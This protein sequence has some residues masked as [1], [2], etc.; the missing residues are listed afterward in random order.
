M[1]INISSLK[2]DILDI[3]LTINIF[4][5]CIFANGRACTLAVALTV[6]Y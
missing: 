3:L 1:Q 6:T 5:V 2:D 4:H